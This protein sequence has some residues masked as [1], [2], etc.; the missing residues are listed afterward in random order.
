M[1]APAAAGP[2]LP[3]G[4]VTYSVKPRGGVVHTLALANFQNRIVL[5]LGIEVEANGPLPPFDP[6][7]DAEERGN[8][9][10]EVRTER[11]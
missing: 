2:Q 1:T 5:A 11:D 10:L 7:L 9:V 4:L 3:V 8:E 6:Q